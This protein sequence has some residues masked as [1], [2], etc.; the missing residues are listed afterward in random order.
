VKTGETEGR[1]VEVFGDLR[2]GETLLVR[3][4]DEIRPGARLT[5]RATDPK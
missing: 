1:Q 2:E 5:V 3:G 4:T